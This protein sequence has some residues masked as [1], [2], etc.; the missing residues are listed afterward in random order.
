MVMDRR[1]RE[2]RKSKG[3]TD[4]KAWAEQQDRGYE[5]TALKLPDGVEFYKL[6]PGTHAI[7][8]MPYIVGK[9][10]KRAD[11][12]FEH[13]EREYV[14]HRIPG[15]DGRVKYYCCRWETFKKKCPVEILTQNGTINDPELIKKLKG[16]VRHLWVVNDKPGDKKNKLKVFDTN[17]YNRG[18][19]FGEM[20]ADA[21]NSVPK[22]AKFSDLKGGLTLQLTVKEQTF[23]G[24]K[25]NAV[26]RIDFLPRDYDY[27]D[28]MLEAAP[29][30]DDCLVDI[31][32]DEMIKVLTHEETDDDDRKP[33]TKDDGDD[34]KPVSRKP[35][36]DDDDDPV[37]DDD[38][39][40]P[41]KRKPVDDEG[42]DDDD[43]P[44]EK[45]AKECG[46]K[47]GM[48]VIYDG[49]KC[50]ITRISGDGTS[51]TLEDPD[52][53]II[54]AV[55][56]ESV[57]LLK[58]AKPV[59]DEDDDDKPIK[60]KKKPPVDDDDGDDDPVDDEDDDSPKKKKPIKDDDDGDDDEP[61]KPKKKPVVTDEDDDDN[62][63]PTG[64]KKPG[65]R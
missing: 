62:P 56:P 10:N 31:G 33:D 47:E 49:E 1:E 16:T 22:Y 15:P 29:C 25:Y 27:P 53:N 57:K 5:P 39:P 4:A 64:K 42:D 28:S 12:G 32:Y 48:T 52:E 20:L 18:M 37:D 14:A 30:L 17:H 58:T 35:S 65:K 44:K 34:D 8:F 36:N 24:G 41:T 45:T 46:L 21:L 6:E 60:P 38:K 55:S 11:E 59:D 51:L 26:T 43:T 61:I 63:R 19:G 23:P 9:G 50:T 54:K 3:K 7:D 2:A 13:F 40:A